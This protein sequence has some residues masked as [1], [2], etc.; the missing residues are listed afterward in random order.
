MPFSA[1][2]F[3]APVHT[4][5]IKIGFSFCPA[6]LS[7]VNFILR[8]A[9][10]P[11]LYGEIFLPLQGDARLY[12]YIVRGQAV[13]REMLEMWERLSDELLIVENLSNLYVRP[14]PDNESCESYFLVRISHL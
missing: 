8:P 14:F 13:N 4:S 5:M 9:T 7:Y 1:V 10:E 11:R 12:L 2:S 6:N 3:E